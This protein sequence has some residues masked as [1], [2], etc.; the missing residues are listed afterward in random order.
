M[1]GH[2]VCLLQDRCK[3]TWA[4]QQISL[5]WMK[6]L[7]AGSKRQL[8]GCNHITITTPRPTRQQS[9]HPALAVQPT[10]APGWQ[11]SA[12]TCRRLGRL[13]QYWL[14]NVAASDSMEKGGGSYCVQATCW[15]LH[16]FTHQKTL[17][18]TCV[19]SAMRQLP[20]PSPSMTV[21]NRSI[22][23]FFSRSSL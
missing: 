1:A 21:F 16:T 10:G 19:T 23:S 4:P 7:A 5:H 2:I 12:H 20:P 6:Q 18:K 11:N 3:A 8:L 22:S 14:Q 17:V 9:Q 13:K 15:L